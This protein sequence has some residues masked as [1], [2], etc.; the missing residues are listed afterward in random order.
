MALGLMA[1]PAIRF[2]DKVFDD[3]TESVAIA[4]GAAPLLNGS[5]QTLL[6]DLYTPTGD[7]A[8]LRP[9]VVIIHG[10][11]FT[12][13]SRQAEP[14]V[15]LARNFASRGYVVISIDY[16]LV[17]VGSDLNAA[18]VMAAD[19]ARAAVRWLRMNAGYLAI[20][21]ERIAAIGNSAGAATA[22]TVAYVQSLG[23]SGNPGWPSHVNAV[24]DLWGW[25][26]VPSVIEP[27][28]A[29]LSIVHGQIDLVV[30]YSFAMALQQQASVAGL[31]HQLVTLAGA[32]HEP[33]SRYFT[34]AHEHVL[35]HFHEHLKLG[36]LAGLTQIG[37]ATASG[38]L[39]LASCGKPWD[40]RVSA[41]GLVGAPM[42][43]AGVGTFALDPWSVCIHGVTL[44]PPISPLPVL[45]DYI[46]IPATLSG[47]TL[48][49][50]E[51]HVSP[52]GVPR[53]LTNCL[54]TSIG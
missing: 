11:G 26:P 47:C 54:L 48:G 30:F 16:R 45:L 37:T 27:W 23:M 14:L 32:G 34:D 17:P 8:L 19:D 52:Q 13:G 15:R 28:E 53:V 40:F 9:A 33:W 24:A 31:P 46:P 3:V 1:Q 25:L 38:Q 50:Q 20:D 42:P 21:P 18:L 6:L 4:Y 43:I 39:V 12:T 5:A 10:G 49:W 22:M 41:V 44:F 36:H 35:A 51:L 2:R 29:P 7:D